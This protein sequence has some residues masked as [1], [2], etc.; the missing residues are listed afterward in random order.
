MKINI[1]FLCI[2][3]MLIFSSVSFSEEW[4]EQTNKKAQEHAIEDYSVSEG[5]YNILVN[6]CKNK[7]K[8]PDSCYVYYG[9]DEVINEEYR[10]LLENLHNKRSIKSSNIEKS[11]EKIRLALDILNYIYTGNKSDRRIIATDE[12]GECT[13]YNLNSKFIYLFD[14]VI[15]STLKIDMDGSLVFSG[16]F[17]VMFGTEDQV[18]RGSNLEDVEVGV[19]YKSYM[20]GWITMSKSADYARAVKAASLLFEKA[21]KGAQ[22]SEF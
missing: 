7:Q 19:N 13:F 4:S 14:H 2:F 1:S 8:S 3:L 18:L 17:G 9:Y 10:N 5:Y 20:P 12:T 11:N 16:D 22:S 21:C 6:Y 15:P